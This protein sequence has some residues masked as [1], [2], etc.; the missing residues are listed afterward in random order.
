MR[1]SSITCPGPPAGVRLIRIVRLAFGTCPIQLPWASVPALAFN[2]TDSVFSSPGQPMFP[3]WRKPRRPWPL[4]LGPWW[5][6]TP[7][8]APRPISAIPRGRIIPLVSTACGRHDARLKEKQKAGLHCLHSIRSLKTP[9]QLIRQPIAGQPSLPFCDFLRCPRIP[10]REQRR[11]I[12]VG[13]VFQ[14]SMK[15]RLFNRQC[16][17][18]AA[19]GFRRRVFSQ[20]G[21][22]FPWMLALEPDRIIQVSLLL[23]RGSEKFIPE[24]MQ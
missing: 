5:E 22:G 21:Q 8:P 2:P 17:A 15:G 20:F 18:F 6:P 9:F 14:M 16:S 23:A 19:P 12:R 13:A 24:R 3:S 11:G 10:V 7:S 1:P 4:Q